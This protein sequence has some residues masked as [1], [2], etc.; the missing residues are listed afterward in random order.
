MFNPFDFFHL[1]YKDVIKNYNLFFICLQVLKNNPFKVVIDIPFLILPDSV[2][3]C[4][5]SVVS[6]SLLVST[7]QLTVESLIIRGNHPLK[8]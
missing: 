8:F 6:L 3:N 7:Y 5:N 4:V 2:Y 1:S